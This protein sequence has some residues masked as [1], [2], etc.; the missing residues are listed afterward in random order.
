MARKKRA[1]FKHYKQIFANEFR[2]YNAGKLAK[3]VMAGLTVA[4]VALPLALAFGAASVGP[5]NAG[6]GVAAG[7]ITAV[8]T[9]IVTGMLG[10]GSFQIS[11]PTGAMTVILG[12]I[13]A[14]QYGLQG[15]LLASLMAGVILF[16]AGLLRFGKIVQFIPK[17]VVVGFTSGIAI[18]IALGQLGNFFGVALEG[19]STIAKLIYFFAHAL[20]Q[21]HL[22]TLLCSLAVVLLMVVYPKKLA[23]YVPGSLVAIIIITIAVKVFSIDIRLIGAIPSSLINEVRLDLSQVTMP[24]LTSLIGTAFTIAALGMIES[25]LCGTS[26]A[27]MKKEKFDSNVELVAQGLGNMVVPFFGGVPSTAAMAR[28]SVAIKSGGQTRLT[29]LF[30]SLFLIACIFLLSGVIGIVPY[31]ALAGVLVVTAWRMNEWKTIRYYFKKKLWDAVAMFLI[32]MIATVLLDL[33]YAII[34]GVIVSM[35]ML[36]GKL[37]AIQLEL[38]RADDVNEQ[39]DGSMLL[40]CT[41]ALFF[42]NEKEINKKLESIDMPYEKLAIVMRG[43]V[44]LDISAVFEL[45]EVVQELQKAGKKVCFTGV[46]QEIMDTFVKC[47]FDEIVGKDNFYPTVDA[48]LAESKAAAN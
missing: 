24:M 35:I 39:A 3:D 36:V 43:I 44:Y 12:G 23:Q 15:M 38:S 27:A 46:R 10:G 29:S 45:T 21:I 28:T 34:I 17:P 19:E 33:T 7:L 32:T 8:V 30:Q 9:G 11:G 37:S 16:V 4:A 1:F 47:G 5:E 26:A 2:G 25:L 18:V 41:G 14:G 6:I 13:V 40:Y 20:P 31:A 22:P 42:A 48:F